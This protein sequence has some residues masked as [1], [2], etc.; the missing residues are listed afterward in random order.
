MVKE[1]SLPIANAVTLVVELSLEEDAVL[2]DGLLE[3]TNTLSTDL[4][5][6]QIPHRVCWYRQKEEQDVC[7][8]VANDEERDYMTVSYTH[9][10]E[11]PFWH[12]AGAQRQ[13]ADERYPR[14]CRA[15][16]VVPR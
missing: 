16:R 7:F 1:F 5:G 14:V 3:L 13:V 2:L 12:S 10:C 6:R 11:D 4:V 9:L 8:D 15:G